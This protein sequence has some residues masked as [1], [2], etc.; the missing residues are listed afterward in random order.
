MSGEGDGVCLSQKRTQFGK[1]RVTRAE[2]ADPEHVAVDRMRHEL[3]KGGEVRRIDLVLRIARNVRTEER[4]KGFWGES[5]VQAK[6]GRSIEIGEL[7][8]GVAGDDGGEW[9]P[10]GRIRGAVRIGKEVNVARGLDDV[11]PGN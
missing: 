10:A 8:V 1:G 6:D 9:Q 5:D 11:E 2:H 7:I 4:A 3:V